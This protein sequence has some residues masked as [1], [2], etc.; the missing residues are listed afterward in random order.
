MFVRH[1]LMLLIIYY[2]F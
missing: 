2:K 1:D